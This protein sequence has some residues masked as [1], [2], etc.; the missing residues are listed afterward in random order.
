MDIAEVEAETDELDM[1]AASTAEVV[2]NN[3]E[4]VVANI[5]ASVDTAGAAGTV[6]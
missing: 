3:H 5:E 2:P 6:V 1:S 4:P